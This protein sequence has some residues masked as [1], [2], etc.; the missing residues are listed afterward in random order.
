[1]KITTTL[2]E[3]T[4]T[5]RLGEKSLK[6]RFRRR[7]VLRILR[8]WNKRRAKLS[9]APCSPP[10]ARI[11]ASAS[12]GG[13]SG[14]NAPLESLVGGVLAGRFHAWRGA[15]GHRYI[16]SVFPVNG[17]EPDG[18]LPDYAEA[19]VIAVAPGAAHAR[20]MVSLCHCEPSADA[21]A[22]E[23]F[24]AQAVATGAVEWHVHFLAMDM[25]QRC[26]VIADIEAAQ[27]ALDSR[28]TKICTAA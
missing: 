4:K 2:A 8:D 15:S 12:G 3:L 16:C 28:P 23:F 5:G 6:L 27:R 14:S 18:G 20:R 17:M 21:T 9:N 7:A 13:R 1:M 24:I 25:E 10:N 11:P 26:A 19:I 22:R